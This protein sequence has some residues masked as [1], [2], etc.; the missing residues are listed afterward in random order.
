[1]STTL[2]WNGKNAHQITYVAKICKK[3]PYS[4]ELQPP[5]IPVDP[6]QKIGRDLFQYV[7]KNYVIII[8]LTGQNCMNEI[9]RKYQVLLRLQRRDCPDMVIP[10]YSSKQCKR[11]THKW[12]FSHKSSSPRHPQ[13]NGLAESSR[14]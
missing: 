2:S 10:Q 11:F 8:V 1:M 12:Q 13:S 9:L 3:N 4:K 5:E 7:G 14:R 6:Q